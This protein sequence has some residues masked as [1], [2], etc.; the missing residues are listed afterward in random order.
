MFIGVGIPG[1]FRVSKPGL[2]APKQS[3][4]GVIGGVR[5]PW[6]MLTGYWFFCG[7]WK[8]PDAITFSFTIDDGCSHGGV[9]GAIWFLAMASC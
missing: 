5:Q 1:N 2:K 6:G 4:S 9:G 7:V 3:D 8:D